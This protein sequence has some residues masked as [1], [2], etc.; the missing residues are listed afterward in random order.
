MTAEQP[1]QRS[2]S[3]L[4]LVMATMVALGLVCIVCV[5]NFVRSGT[6][7]TNGIINNLRQLD[8]AKQQWALDHNQTG[9]VVV[10]KDDVA[11]YLRQPDGWVESVAG[12]SYSLRT[13]VES[14]EAQLT[15]QVDGQPK[16]TVVRLGTNGIEIISPTRGLIQ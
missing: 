11:P 12:E 13:L 7:K 16:G 14:P 9:A 5:P 15:R 2:Y 3:S 4:W 6:T 10:T 1:K 8:G